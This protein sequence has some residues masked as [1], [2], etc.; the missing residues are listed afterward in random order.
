MELAD[1][2]RQFI[3]RVASVMHIECR[4]EIRESHD[5][6]RRAIHVALTTSDQAE[7]LIGNQGENLRAFEYILRVVV[8]RQK[9]DA[10]IVSLDIN[11]Y[12][13]SRE[14]SAI[15]IARAAVQRVR[16][17]GKSEAL[18]PMAAFERR[19]VHAELM[20]HPD[21]ATE[22]IGEEPQRR[23]VVKLS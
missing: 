22:S 21:I 6:D 8:S 1:I 5:D 23:V 14:L 19:A 11:E 17:T 15:E 18:P 2:I 20:E 3:D 12:K 13:K 7:F 9:P 4:V 10:P 16:T